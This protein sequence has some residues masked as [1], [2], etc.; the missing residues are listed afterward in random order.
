MDCLRMRIG[1]LVSIMWNLR[2]LILIV[3]LCFFSSNAFSFV[4][5]RPD[6]SKIEFTMGCVT[7]S[8]S[9]NNCRTDTTLTIQFI[10]SLIQGDSLTDSLLQR[11]VE[12]NSIDSIHQRRPY[13]INAEQQFIE[14]Y[15]KDKVG[16]TISVVCEIGC[17]RAIIN[18]IGL[19]NGLNKKEFVCR[20]IPIE[21]F[22]I[23]QSNDYFN[24]LCLRNSNDYLGPIIHYKPFQISDFNDV[25]IVDSIRINAQNHRESPVIK[26]TVTEDEFVECRNYK[27]RDWQIPTC[28]KSF[29]NSFKAPIYWVLYTVDDSTSWEC[30]IFKV[31]SS[32]KR[33]KVR[34]VLPTLPNCARFQIQYAVD[35]NQDG[36]LEYI[37]ENH[38][39][40]STLPALFEDYGDHWRLIANGC[41][42][43]Y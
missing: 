1:V 14:K 20:A 7:Y 9:Y 4:L 10:P 25:K 29:D 15:I 32:S 19:V 13:F 43:F 2:N 39:E 38:N 3:T 12:W 26:D 21:E 22:P 36:K 23:P 35:I 33:T 31:K 28:Y 40:K 34:P 37:I 18:E 8:H 5:F 17:F 24:I 41:E 42:V 16:D 11:A 6:S 27:I 30:A